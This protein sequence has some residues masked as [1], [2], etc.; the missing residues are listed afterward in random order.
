M[1]LLQ[2]SINTS[3]CF[4]LPLDHGI[5]KSHKKQINSAAKDKW[6]SEFS[7]P[8]E[9]WYSFW[10]NCP[11]NHRGWRTSAISVP[12]WGDR[13]GDLLSTVLIEANGGYSCN[14][15]LFSFWGFWRMM[16]LI[17]GLQNINC[18]V[19]NLM[20]WNTDGKHQLKDLTLVIYHIGKTYTHL[21][22]CFVI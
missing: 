15:S 2:V 18:F 14:K 21:Y 20:N 7:Y 19:E 6:L 11:I 1:L 8:T 17:R 12:S 16:G 9:T 22:V 13:E 4:S 5:N 10:E 3:N